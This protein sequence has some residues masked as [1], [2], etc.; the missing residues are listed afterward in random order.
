MKVNEMRRM[1]VKFFIERG[2][3]E[4]ASASLFPDNDPSVLFTTAGMHPLVPYLLGESHPMGKR[5]VNVQKC[6]RTDDIDEVGDKTHHTYFEMWGNWSLGDYFKKESIEM[7]YT[8]LTD[9]LK[10]PMERLAVTVFEGSGQ[11]PGDEEAYGCWKS[12]GLT[13]KQIYYYG[14]KE[15]W[16]GPAGKT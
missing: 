1:Y 16:W 11:V 15:N 6:V 7:S 3:K 5:L 2:H 12:V 14:M 13:D 8:F 10:I 4:I 9:K